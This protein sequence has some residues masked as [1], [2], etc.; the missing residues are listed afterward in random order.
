MTAQLP[1]RAILLA[2]I[3]CLLATLAGTPNPVRVITATGPPT[4]MASRLARGISSDANASLQRLGV[5]PSVRVISLDATASQPLDRPW[6]HA[7][8]PMPAVFVF[9]IVLVVEAEV[10]AAPLDSLSAPCGW[11][12]TTV[13]RQ[14]R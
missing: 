9:P 14:L 11:I 13:E 5:V 12:S 7:K 1:A 3:V 4:L 10:E 6:E 8:V 2:A